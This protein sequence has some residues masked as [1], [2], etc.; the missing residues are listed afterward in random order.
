MEQIDEKIMSVIDTIKRKEDECVELKAKV[1]DKLHEINQAYEEL[2]AQY[3]EK[4]TNFIGKKVLILWTEHNF[5]KPVEGYF[6]GFQFINEFGKFIYAKVNK[7]KKDGSM[8]LCEF[9]Y[10]KLPKAEEIG[11]IILIEN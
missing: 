9:P 11:S 7:C 10:Y 3:S 5:T 2:V 4:Y 6:M 8:S 1:G